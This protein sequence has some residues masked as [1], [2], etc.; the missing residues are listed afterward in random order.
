MRSRT[1]RLIGLFVPLVLASGALRAGESDT[2]F[3]D[4]FEPPGFEVQ[5]PDIVVAPGVEGTWCYYFRTP[6]PDTLGIRR[7]A[8]TMTPGM[9]HLI[10]FTT[11]DEVQ[12]PG[13]LTQGP[14]AGG[15]GEIPEWNYAAHDLAEELV[16]PADDGGGTPL[17]IEIAPDQAAFLQMHVVNDSA[18]PITV[19]ASLVAEALAP[20][21]DYTRTATY[22]TTNI[23]LSIPPGAVGYTVEET[24]PTPDGVKFWWLSTRT[25]RFA[26]LAEIRDADVQLVVSTDWEHPEVATFP[27][28]DFHAF[29]SGGLTYQCTYNN[30]T[31]V[32]INF[33]DSEL[34][35]ENC[36]GIGYFFPANDG[37]RF[38]V[39]SIG[40]L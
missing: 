39:N 12:P 18:E 29:A 22:L 10:L 20:G 25:H 4:G 40:P 28:P 13:S 27:P 33:G 36:I 15:S 6:N 5:T 30:P 11:T 26:T 37:A 9:H 1:G 16:L 23:N 2:V 31:N 38:C 8:S 14:C 3:R 35:D 7:W 19:S 17:A 24:C 32:T 21:V 34:T